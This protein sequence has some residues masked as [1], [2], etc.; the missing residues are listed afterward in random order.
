MNILVTG[1]GGQLGHE[2]Q[3][4]PHR[5]GDR[6]MF[7]DI[8]GGYESLDITDRDA[9]LRT[10]RENG[11]D[12]IVNCAAYTNVDKAESDPDLAGKLNSVAPGILADAMKE[13]G[14]TLIHIS[15]DY[16]FHGDGN[17]P[18]REDFPTAPLGVYGR[19]KLEGEKLI[20]ASGCSSIIIRTAWLHSP[21]GKNF[22]KTMRDL[23]ASR[24]S[25]NVVF[26]QV[27]SPTFAGD[28]AAAICHI[29]GTG[30]L[31][32]TGIY[33]FSNEGVCSWYDFAEAI[34]EMS[35]NRCDIRPCHS[36]EY[37][38]PV[39]RPHYSVLDKTL[40]KKTF[41]ISIP[42]WRESLGR[43]IAEIENS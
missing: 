10:V 33:H 18:I 3:I 29:I 21:F 11:I 20:A 38:S 2:M 13:A 42:H 27:G 17:V 4:V 40:I 39:R 23:T 26:D 12:V 24:D 14:G 30:Q 9:V 15:T 8:A 1:A 43:C 28:L 36:D 5:D 22:V 6:Y 31:H 16:V 7:T 19:T 32:K 37:P 25:L 34:R 35:G 41:G